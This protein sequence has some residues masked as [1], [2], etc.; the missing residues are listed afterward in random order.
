MYSERINL[1][2]G[3]LLVPLGANPNWLLNEN[4]NLYIR[5]L[6]KKQ[7]LK[8]PDIEEIKFLKLREIN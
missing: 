1:G 7:T 5:L 6:N 4:K 3:E 2:D 8:A